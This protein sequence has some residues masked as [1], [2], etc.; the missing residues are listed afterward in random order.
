[1]TLLWFRTMTR[2]K[3][4][5]NYPFK[6]LDNDTNLEKK[7]VKKFCFSSVLV[8]SADLNYPDKTKKT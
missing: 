1:M 8:D 3:V 6:N 7:R 4:P 5:D 2:F